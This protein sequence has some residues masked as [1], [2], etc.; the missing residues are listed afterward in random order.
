M[1]RSHLA[2]ALH[3]YDRGIA[4][5]GSVHVDRALLL[6]DEQQHEEHAAELLAVKGT[7]SARAAAAALR[8]VLDQVDAVAV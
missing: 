7:R 1:F 6:A 5:R 8:A 4:A 3:F 2:T